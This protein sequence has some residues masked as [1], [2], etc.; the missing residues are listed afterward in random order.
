ML[1]CLYSTSSVIFHFS[2]ITLTTSMI[3][4]C[5]ETRWL[6][7]PSS[8]IFCTLV[9]YSLWSRGNQLLP[10]FDT[11]AVITDYWPKRKMNIAL[12]DLSLLLSAT[13]MPNSSNQLDRYI[14]PCA[15]LNVSC[16]KQKFSIKHDSQVQNSLRNRI[17]KLKPL[18]NI[19]DILKLFGGATHCTKD[20]QH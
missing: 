17:L 4:V 7:N 12:H 15:I 3:L 16:K 18:G 10:K 5:N 14:S 13:W 9:T 19:H 6:E 11:I 8:K 1:F 2:N 20:V